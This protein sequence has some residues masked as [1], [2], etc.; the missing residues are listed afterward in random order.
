MA[1]RGRSQL[2]ETRAYTRDGCKHDRPFQEISQN[3]GA[4]SVG[5]AISPNPHLTPVSLHRVP[6]FLLWASPPSPPILRSPSPTPRRRM[7]KLVL[8]STV[9]LAGCA[10]LIPMQPK[11]IMSL[12]TVQ[13]PERAKV[14]YGPEVITQ[15]TDSGVRKYVF[16]DSLVKAIVYPTT[17]GFSVIINNKTDHTIKI[18][19]DE[20]AIVGVNGSSMR[21]MH[22]GV[23]Y[24]DRNNSQ[25]PSVI[26]AHGHI[27]DDVVPTERVVQ[28]YGSW[29]SAPM[30][31]LDYYY[32]A[33]KDTTLAK[34]RNE[35]KGK[36]MQL[37]LPLSIEDVTN[38]YLFTFTIDDIARARVMTSVLRMD[39]GN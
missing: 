32:L 27:A 10:G 4:R 23:K 14:R 2:T 5:A 31:P 22:N 8:L 15:V 13:R 12:T 11:P 26:V 1:A 9:L 3:R 30:L 35:Y 33:D 29:D 16:E 24:I 18:M 21:L 39:V 7:R 19:W 17:T 6:L 25:P 38:D 34:L 37:L 20:A 28:G 36:T